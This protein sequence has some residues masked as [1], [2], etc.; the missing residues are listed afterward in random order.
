MGQ[1]LKIGQTQLSYGTKYKERKKTEDLNCFSKS[2]EFNAK[3]A[4]RLGF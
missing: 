3:S 4:K 2:S 1:I